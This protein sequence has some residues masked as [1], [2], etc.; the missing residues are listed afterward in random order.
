MYSVAGTA[1]VAPERS[2]AISVVEPSPPPS[3]PRRLPATATLPARLA[4]LRQLTTSR[5]LLASTGQGLTLCRVTSKSCFAAEPREKSFIF[6]SF[7]LLSPI[8][9]SGAKEI[10]SEEE[11]TRGVAPQKTSFL[12]PPFFR[13]PFSEERPIKK[14][15]KDTCEMKKTGKKRS[16]VPC[17]CCRAHQKKKKI[18]RHT[19]KRGTKKNSSFTSASPT[20][21]AALRTPSPA[22]TPGSASTP[23]PARP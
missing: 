1:I 7:F 3:N 8:A 23:R 13:M 2:S 9:R 19:Q 16:F 14:S 17:C 12:S 22:A 4:P 21:T 10:E 6:P 5:S 20:P 15:Y 11:E 18:K